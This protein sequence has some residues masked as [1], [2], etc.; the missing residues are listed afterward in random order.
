MI[1][2]RVT[3]G[4]GRKVMGAMDDPSTT[5]SLLIHPINQLSTSMPSQVRP[6]CP[7]PVAAEKIKM[8]IET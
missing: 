1:G 3:I 8:K 5:R 2:V 6:P 7:F 4:F